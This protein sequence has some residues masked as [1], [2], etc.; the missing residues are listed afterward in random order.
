M[1]LKKLTLTDFGVFHGRHSIDL[2][3][4]PSRPIVLFGGKNGAGKSTILE[5]VRL[6][7][8]GGG[9]LSVRSKE[10][11]FEYLNKRIHR[12][13][14]ALIQP[15]YASVEIEFDYGDIGALH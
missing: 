8:Y 9:A 15:Q 1:I 4:K 6:G 13:P 10:E 7:F 11:Y 12:N 14:N 2:L 3:P 5:A